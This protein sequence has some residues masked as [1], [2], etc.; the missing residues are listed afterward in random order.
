[1]KFTLLTA[2]R[3]DLNLVPMCVPDE[4]VADV[5]AH[6][7]KKYE[8]NFA[9]RP[10]SPMHLDLGGAALMAM[11]ALTLSD[12]DGPAI[13]AFADHVDLLERVFAAYDRN[14]ANLR[15]YGPE[16]GF[17]VEL[18]RVAVTP[19][20]HGLLPRETVRAIHRLLQA[21]APQAEKIANTVMDEWEQQFKLRQ[22]GAP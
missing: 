11:P 5:V 1:M 13:T 12:E 19:H 21:E 8:T 15:R 17:K 20:R 16:C 7:A 18:V 3:D 14:W 6:Y 9:L 2:T 22:R 4:H 10:I